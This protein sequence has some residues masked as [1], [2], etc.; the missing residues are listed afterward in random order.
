M[1][2]F[3]QTHHVD[4]ILCKCA[5]YFHR[6]ARGASLGATSLVVF[7][8]ITNSPNNFKWAQLKVRAPRIISPFLSLCWA[9]QL[10]VNVFIL[11]YASDIWGRRNVTGIKDYGYHASVN[12]DRLIDKLIV[13]DPNF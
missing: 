12:T 11:L 3:S 5:I 2:A 8:A 9:L 13:K 7:Q 6:V 10:F 1:T 4:Y